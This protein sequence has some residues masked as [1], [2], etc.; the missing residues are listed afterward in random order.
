MAEP[1]LQIRLGPGHPDLEIRRVAVT[2]NFFRPF[3]PQFGLK[4][5]GAPPLD[6]PLF[7]KHVW[8]NRQT[9]RVKTLS[10][11]NLDASRNYKREKKAHFR[12]TCVAQKSCKNS[13]ITIHHA[14][15]HFRVSRVLLDGLRKKTGFS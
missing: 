2:K 11:T 15:C 14:R 8:A 9:I 3:G 4:V 5:R 10:H 7:L 1:D 13:Q 6:P 12:F